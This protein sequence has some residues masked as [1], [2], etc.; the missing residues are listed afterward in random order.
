[1]ERGIGGKKV[2]VQCR[3]QQEQ[4]LLDLET[5]KLFYDELFPSWGNLRQKGGKEK[6]VSLYAIPL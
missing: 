5:Q 4:Q 2:V 3:S 1:M 6:E